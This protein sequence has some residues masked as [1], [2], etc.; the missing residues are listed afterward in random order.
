MSQL[1]FR[2]VE[3]STHRI[4]RAAYIVFDLAVNSGTA[5]AIRYLQRVAGVAKDGVIG[6]KTLAAVA[7]LQPVRFVERMSD[8]REAFYRSLPTF[9]TFG[10]GWMRRLNEVEALAHVWAAVP[11]IEVAA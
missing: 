2:L 7:A 6:S 10:K 4:I 8:L 5:R 1:A 9:P 11:P 3:D